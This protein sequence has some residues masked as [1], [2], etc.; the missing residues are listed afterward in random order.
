MA[1]IFLIYYYLLLYTFPININILL[2][3]NK[4]K[5]FS[6]N[7]KNKINFFLFNAYKNSI[8]FN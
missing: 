5:I 8:L 1:K 6:K 3:L 7:R 2:M 4:K